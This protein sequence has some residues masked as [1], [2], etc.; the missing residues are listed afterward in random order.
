MKRDSEYLVYSFEG[1]DGESS[2]ESFDAAARL[3]GVGAESEVCDQVCDAA[4]R[5]VIRM[6]VAVE[7][8]FRNMISTGAALHGHAS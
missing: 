5:A 3:R 1:D 6:R 7:C 8:L 4:D 2:E